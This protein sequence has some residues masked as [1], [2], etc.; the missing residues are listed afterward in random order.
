MD[1]ADPGRTGLGEDWGIIESLLPARWMEMAR[2]TGAF[3]RARGI[4]DA[5]VLLQ[6]MLIHL[7]EGYRRQSLERLHPPQQR[8]LPG[9]VGE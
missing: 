8:L 2:E 4:A 9:F 6:V 5:R 7:A 3:L 1:H